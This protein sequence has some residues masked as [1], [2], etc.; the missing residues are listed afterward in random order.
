MTHKSLLISF[1]IRLNFGALPTDT[2]APGFT[3]L[4]PSME[5]F[6]LNPGLC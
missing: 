1:P 3:P 5:E 6:F 4:Y 2:N